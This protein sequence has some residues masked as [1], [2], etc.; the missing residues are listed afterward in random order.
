MTVTEQPNPVS[1]QPTAHPVDVI[2]D[3]RDV[4]MVFLPVIDL[5]SGQ[6]VGLEA[7][8]RGPAGTALERPTALFAAA[9]ERGRAAELDWVCRAAA[10]TAVLATDIPPSLALFVNSR[11]ETLGVECPADLTPVIARAEALLRVV[12]EITERDLAI[13]PQGLL[14]AVD[15]A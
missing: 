10:F 1:E 11:P 12:V 5:R 13:D 8:A 3:Q 15:R 14:T 4:S 6:V 2:V 9:A 7:L